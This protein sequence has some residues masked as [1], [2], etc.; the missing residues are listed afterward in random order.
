MHIM[1]T[2]IHLQDIKDNFATNFEIN[3][4]ICVSAI[5][6]D[7]QKIV[8]L[9]EKFPDSIIPAFGIHPW[10]AKDAK[11]GW[12]QRLSN[13]LEEYPCALVGETGLDRLKNPE[14]EP[15]NEVFL[16]HIEL[17]KK[18]NRAL[19]IHN[20][21]AQD[22]MENYW[23]LMPEK[24]VFHSYNGKIE[25]LKK[26]LLEGGH[27]SFSNSIL[28]NVDKEKILQFM[29]ENKIMLETDAPYQGRIED[30]PKLLAE[31][32][33]IRGKDMEAIIYKNSKDFVDVG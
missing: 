7:W 5:E 31:V 25:F 29:P 19:I 20:V 11:L 26:I 16:K 9:Y 14:F 18:F 22:W 6:D 8:D 15:Q 4:F 3:K 10:Y 17:C 1:D 28:K 30:L 13:L 23:N 32:S 21:K 27:V 12:E 33:R 24:F 2:H